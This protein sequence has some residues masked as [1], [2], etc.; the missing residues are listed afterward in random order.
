MEKSENKQSVPIRFPG[1][2]VGQRGRNY[3]NVLIQAQRQEQKAQATLQKAFSNQSAYQN[4]NDSV[5]SKQKKTR[6]R[7][8]CLRVGSV[9]PRKK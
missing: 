7:G 9:Q 6:A 1:Q 8:K 4:K 5:L 2:I 3:V